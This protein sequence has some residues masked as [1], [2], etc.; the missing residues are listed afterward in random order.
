MRNNSGVKSVV[1][2][3]EIYLNSRDIINVL[4]LDYYISVKNR[5]LCEVSYLEGLLNRME[6]Y[7][8]QIKK[9]VEKKRNEER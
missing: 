2:D 1:Y 4:R 9:Q 7:E 3:G 6:N 8:D 5:D